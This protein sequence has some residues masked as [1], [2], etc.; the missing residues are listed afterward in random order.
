M[1]AAA[2]DTFEDINV[3][4]EGTRPPDHPLLGLENVVLTPHVAALSVE[5]SQNVFT[6]GVQ[7]VMAILSGYWPRSENVVNPTVIPRVPLKPYDEQTS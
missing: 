1:P 5:A 7:N 6:G 4:T 3:H 2:L